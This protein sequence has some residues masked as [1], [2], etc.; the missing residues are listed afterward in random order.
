LFSD[1]E[2]Q[3][4]LSGLIRSSKFSVSEIRT[5]HSNK[6]TNELVM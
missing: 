4:A 6:T 3:L 2:E 5:K 1:F